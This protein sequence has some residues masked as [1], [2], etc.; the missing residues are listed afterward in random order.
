MI[1]DFEQI[2]EGLKHDR[3]IGDHLGLP[4]Q[5]HRV[6]SNSLDNP[7]VISNIDTIRKK[8]TYHSTLLGKNHLLKRKIRR[9][10]AQLKMEQ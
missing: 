2:I 5:D 7:T 10:A 1:P 6:N 8:I 3:F 9:L 4:I